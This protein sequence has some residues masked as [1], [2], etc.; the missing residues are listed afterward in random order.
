[1]ELVKDGRCRRGWHSGKAPLDGYLEDQA[2]FADALLQ[3]FEVDSDPRWLE[4]ARQ[5][6]AAMVRDF[7]AEDGGFYFTARDHEALIARSKTPTE[8]SLP[9]GAAMAT[10]ALLRGG[11][12]L[13]DQE[14]YD[15]AVACLRAN[16]DL[17]QRAPAHLASLVAALQFH[18]ADPR[19][20]VIAGEPGDPRT[21]ALLQAA[22]RRFPRVA[23]TTLVHAGNQ[24]A[25]ARLSPVFVGK[26]PVDGAPAAYVCRRGVCAAPVSDPQRLLQD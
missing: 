8:S 22:W 2:M 16:H 4:A 21:Q 13:G 23:V 5:L 26:V 20:V 14:L 25:L 7:G 19:E 12:L 6:L 1:T 15:R 9:S 17:L 11:L 24:E 18:L 10:M 3:L